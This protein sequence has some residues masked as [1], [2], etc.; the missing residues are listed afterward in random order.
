MPDRDMT[1]ATVF[2]P[3]SRASTSSNE[4][5]PAVPMAVRAVAAIT[6]SAIGLLLLG[7][8]ADHRVLHERGHEGAVGGED[9]GAAV[10]ATVPGVR[11]VVGEQQPVGGGERLVERQ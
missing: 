7:D 2:V 3:S 4:P 11:A 1:S 9:I 6:A 10:A 8:G 5:L